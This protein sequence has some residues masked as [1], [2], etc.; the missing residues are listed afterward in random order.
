MFLVENG[1]V[2]IKDEKGRRASFR[3]KEEFYKYCPWEEFAVLVD[4]FEYLDYEP[5]R[6]LYLKQ[7][8]GKEIEAL[9]PKPVEA[10]EQLIDALPEIL[11]RIAD[12]FFDMY[13]EEAREKKKTFVDRTLAI[14]VDTVVPWPKALAIITGAVEPSE[15]DKKAKEKI[16]EKVKKAEQLKRLIDE[17]T[18]IDEVAE[19]DEGVLLK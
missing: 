11:A 7:L 13:I 16:A 3:N 18:T 17:A 6:N 5:D 2:I 14:A 19:I 12:P 4:D 8:K 10:Y 1:I 15:V 9:E